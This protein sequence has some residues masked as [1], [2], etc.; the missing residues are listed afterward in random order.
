MRRAA[1][2]SLMVVAAALASATPA[3]AADE[4]LELADDPFEI[5]DPLAAAPGAAELAIV[6]FH[7]RARTG[8]WRGTTSLEAEMEVG[9]APG[10]EFRIGQLAAYG[11][12][13]TRRRLDSSVEGEG[14]Q[15]GGR[16]PAWGGVTRLGL[17][18]EV[19]GG[20]GTWPALGVLARLRAVYGPG[21]PGQEA[22]LVALIGRTLIRGERPLGVHLNLGWTARLD[23]LPGERP[24][25]W[26]VNASVG[27]GITRDTALVVTYARE[28][29]ERGER[30]YEIIQA[31]IRH[32]LSGG[33]V[34]GLSV[35]AGLNRDSP[36]FQVGL[37]AQ[38]AFSL[39]GW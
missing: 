25:R 36:A 4:P 17:L 34:I 39:P 20:R 38:W 32:R 31:G 29:G 28:Q 37:A 11:N 22:D 30:D 14:G 23:P 16:I 26:F 18:Y 8:R 1:A 21:R 19:S 9:V 2:G 33:P 5:T 6:G 12:L 13:Q 10:L 15:D 24:H 27:Q 35:G 3:L 7:E